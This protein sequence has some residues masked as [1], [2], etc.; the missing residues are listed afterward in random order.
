MS[1]PDSI[2]AAVPSKVTDTLAPFRCDPFT[3]AKDPGATA[4]EVGRAALATLCR[5][6]LEGVGVGVGWES[7]WAWEWRKA[8][9]SR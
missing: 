1:S 3:I 8:T 5:R 4:V 6:T 9:P 2:V 7:A